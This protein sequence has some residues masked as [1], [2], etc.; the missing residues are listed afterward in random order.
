M[1]IFIVFFCKRQCSLNYVLWKISSSIGYTTVCLVPPALII[2]SINSQHQRAAASVLIN[3]NAESNF[4]KIHSFSKICTKLLTNLLFKGEVFLK[5]KQTEQTYKV[6]IK[7][8]KQANNVC[9]LYITW[10]QLVTDIH[11]FFWKAG[12]GFLCFCIYIGMFSASLF[13][14][15][16]AN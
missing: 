11:R 8:F 6:G 1:T 10:A 16:I 13:L 2:F 3:S 14:S 5:N 15:R 4:V 9:F 12:M 7:Q